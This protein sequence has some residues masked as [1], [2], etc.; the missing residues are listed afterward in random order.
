VTEKTFDEYH[1]YTVERP[2]TLHDRETKQAEFARA[3]GI[4]SEVIYVYD[5][6]QYRGDRYYGSPQTDRSYGTQCNGK[7]WVVREFQNAEANKLGIALPKGRMRFYRRDADGQLEFTGENTIDHTPKDEKVRVITGNAFDLVGERVQTN[8]TE[9]QNER[10]MDETFQITLRNHKAER[11][12]V[13][14]ME[15]L[16]RWTK[17]EITGNTN[18]FNKNDA[19][20]IEFRVQV[21]PGED[22]VITYTAHYDLR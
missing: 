22:K 16:L 2:T 5:G 4:A 11:V 1:L 14:V 6:A 13:R 18:M 7:V 20:T 10:W 19:R 21:E 9:N 15:H 12:E 3:E 17:W 8:F